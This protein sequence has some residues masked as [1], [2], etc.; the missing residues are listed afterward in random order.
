MPT[1]YIYIMRLNNSLDIKIDDTRKAQYIDLTTNNIKDMNEQVN[2]LISK[3]KIDYKKFQNKNYNP[4]IT[5]RM[6]NDLFNFR[7]GKIDYKDIQ[8]KRG[9]IRNYI[10]FTDQIPFIE[11][12]KDDFIK[13]YGEYE[14]LTKSDS[15]RRRILNILDANNILV[16]HKI[17]E[18]MQIKN[19]E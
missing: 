2:N 16:N 5:K 10:I 11:Y 3:C 17:K 9:F 7:M 19:I 15:Y 8:N 13:R 14:F 12:Y 18:T 4:L 6:A 1:K